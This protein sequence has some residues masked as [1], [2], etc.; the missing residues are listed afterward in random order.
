MIDYKNLKTAPGLPTPLGAYVHNN[1]VQFSIFSRNASGVKLILFHNS[2]PDSD[3]TEIALDPFLN[4]TG[5]VWHIWIEGL[6]EGQVYGYRISG[7]YDPANGHRFNENK[8][9]IDPYS[10][11]ITGNFIWDLSKACGIE[12]NVSN[13]AESFS[14]VDSGPYVP[15]S[16]VIN[17]RNE[18]VKSPIRIPENDLIIY[19]LHVKG[20][21][22]HH[23]SKV[24]FPGTFK[25]L[26][27]K[28]PY[29][30]ELGI[31]AV[32]LLP[33]QE[34]DE[35]E[36]I[37]INPFT[38]E[39][40]KNYWGYSTI[41]FFAPKGSYSS[42]GTLGQQVKEFREMVRAFN[43]AGI[44][45]F[46]DVVFNHTHE[47]DHRGPTLSFRGIDNSIYYIL[48]EDKR[49]YKNFSGCGNTVNCNH[50]LVRQFIL[51]A[52]RYWFI[53]MDVDG[54]RFDLASI[55]GRDQKGEILSNPPLIEWIEEDPIL[56]NAKIIAEAW[57]AGGAYLVGKFP[58]RWAEWNGR[59]RDDV[60]RFWRGEK[61]L[62]GAFATRITGS[63]DLY[64]TTSPCRS[65]NFITC[66][67]GF[68]L[69]D[70]VS[71]NNKHNLENGEDNRDG[72]NHNFSCNWGE[73]GPTNNQEIEKIRKRMIKNFIA[74]LFISLGVPMLLSGDEF[75]RTQ[76]GNNNSYCQDNEISWI[77][78]DL[79]QENSDIFEFTKSMILFRK[80]HP[81]L[82]S[83]R[84]YTGEQGVKFTTEDIQWKTP[85]NTT[86]DWDD[87][88]LCIAALI[89]GAY[90]EEIFLIPD[91][92][93][94]MMFN[95]SNTDIV[96]SLPQSPSGRRWKLSINTAAQRGM[97]IYLKDEPIIER[98]KITVEAHSMII[99]TA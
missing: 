32:E 40:L 27:E 23:S 56:R 7:E 97:D 36:N 44:E 84:F 28:I 34:F 35:Y 91:S 78:W 60:R 1:G 85:E 41:A 67:D 21:T 24:N 64:S 53:E 2:E 61:G 88:E 96:F 49:F 39:R 26:T 92:D 83:I 82:R 73:E 62:K 10:R 81:M 11:A 86:P 77:N 12:L 65:I 75:R 99:L 87:E 51:D 70:L 45:V 13:E 14:T 71:Y 69:N 29:L 72:E 48:D 55:L 58:G 31:N 17:G 80:E 68:T 30:K 37:N 95:P 22:A 42:S 5:D 8:L 54:F 52:L 47:G 6:S 16:I 33:I 50:P 4:K 76:K 89:N 9:L 93:F 90:A 59:Y 43:D 98:E 25:G 66:H 94:Y 38:G 15:R 74:T 19:E 18:I 20:F 79:L 46:L 3:F 63:S 57:D